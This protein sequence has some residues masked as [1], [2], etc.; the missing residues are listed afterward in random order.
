MR[1][2]AALAILLGACG[3]LGFDASTD[4]A[5]SGTPGDSVA[6]SDSGA[7]QGPGHIQHAGVLA[8]R[9]PSTGAFSDSFSIQAG[10]AG[11]LVLLFSGCETAAASASASIVV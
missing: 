3:R 5:G 10:K 1:A 11:D 6:G 2:A 8:A 9:N 4:A 7:G